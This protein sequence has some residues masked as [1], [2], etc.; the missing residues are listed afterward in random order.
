M[1]IRILH[2][3]NKDKA[4][5]F[6]STSG[7]AFG[8]LFE[9]QDGLDAYEVVHLF[10]AYAE[11]VEDVPDLRPLVRVRLTEIYGQFLTWL[12]RLDETTCRELARLDRDRLLA[13]LRAEREEAAQ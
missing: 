13:R 10:C 4:A 1:G 3:V 5:L 12:A 9:A 6:C 11:A 2:D 7:Q 8:P